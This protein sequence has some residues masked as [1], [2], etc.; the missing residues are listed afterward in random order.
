MVQLISNSNKQ[1]NS[2][3]NVV[4]FPKM[5]DYY[6]IE[7]T[8]FLETERYREA[9]DLLRF[10]LSCEGLEQHRLE[11]QALLDWLL[12]AFPDELDYAATP[13]QT[14][15]TE[16]DEPSEADLAKQFARSKADQDPAYVTKIL[17]SIIDGPL[18][19][20]KLLALEQLTYL[21]HP[22]IDDAL[23]TWLTQQSLP[24]LLQFHLLRTLRKRG[25]SGTVQF[26]RGHDILTIEVEMTPAQ[27]ED[28][29]Q[30]V[31]DVPERVR[32]QTDIQDPGLSLMA[33][34]LWE[35]CVMVLYGTSGYQ[36]ILD[37]EDSALDICAC[38]LHLWMRE[39]LAGDIEM[40]ADKHEILES[41]G[42]TDALR[43]RMEQ[44]HRQLKGLMHGSFSDQI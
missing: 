31:R 11:W 41:Y 20:Q 3:N 30:A 16:E 7:L 6:Q 35:Q 28:F 25:V 24:A 26:Q 12:G 15:E 13:F 39:L 38:A 21:E 43:F 33:E 29:P 4:L 34:E 19:P 42:I 5:L 14:G 17:N 27:Y 40:E 44:V 8:R 37:E 18:T 2:A 22:D 36:M 1:G 9:I 23:T 10:L 32:Q